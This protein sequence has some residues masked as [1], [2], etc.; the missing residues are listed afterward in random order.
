MSVF[1]KMMKERQKHTQK[2]GE[3]QAEVCA[4][5]IQIHLIAIHFG[6][7]FSWHFKRDETHAFKYIMQ[8]QQQKSISFPGLL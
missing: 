6:Y 2:E 1:I 4:F 8:Q 7:L 5:D 3:F